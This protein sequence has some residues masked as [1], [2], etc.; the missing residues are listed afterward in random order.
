VPSAVGLGSIPPGFWKT[1]LQVILLIYEKCLFLKKICL[2]KMLKAH[3]DF[4]ET[5]DLG[6]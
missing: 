3:R 4:D 2:I 6:I 5:A 1:K